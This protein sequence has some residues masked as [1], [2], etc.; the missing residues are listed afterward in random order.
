MEKTDKITNRQTKKQTNRQA[1]NERT[2][3]ERKNKRDYEQNRPLLLTHHLQFRELQS[4]QAKLS[5]Y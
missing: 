1:D 2:E 5:N 3:E 4:K